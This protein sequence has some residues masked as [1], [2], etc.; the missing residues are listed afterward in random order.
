MFYT[1]IPCP[2]WVRHEPEYLNKATIYFPVIGW[3]V[4]LVGWLAYWGGVAVFTPFIAIIFS[5][6]ATVLTTGSFHEDG[7][8]DVCDGFGGGWTPDRILDIM[9]DSRVGTYAVVGLMLLFGLK[10]SCLYEMTKY[11]STLSFL[12]LF[13]SAHSLSR[14]SAATA[15]FTHHY[16]RKNDDSKAKPLAKK[17][18]V[19]LLAFMTILGIAPLLVWSV[20]TFHWILLIAIVPVYL[21][22][23]LMAR[24]FEKWIN[25]YTGDCLGAIQQVSEVV[26]YLSVIVLWKFF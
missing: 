12:F 5:L 11:G 22:K 6:A 16:A 8:A 23:V 18:S 10:M 17:M 15:I 9:K 24:Y 2:K 3:L 7:F 19:S 1:R 21:V 13:L 14:W 20:Y 26:F 25:G 4:A